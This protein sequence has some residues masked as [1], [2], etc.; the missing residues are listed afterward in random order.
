MLRMGKNESN[1][2]LPSLL[3]I[4]KG[5]HIRIYFPIAPLT[6]GLHAALNNKISISN[7]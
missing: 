4:G 2:L 3:K 5:K 7:Q 1:E 6:F